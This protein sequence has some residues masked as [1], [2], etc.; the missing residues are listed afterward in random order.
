[1]MSFPEP[2]IMTFAPDEP[3]RVSPEDNADASTFWKLV[4][5]VVSPDV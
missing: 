5:F 1:M 3:V 4:T 2:P